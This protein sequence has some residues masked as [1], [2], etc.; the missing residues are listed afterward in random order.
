MS[1]AKISEEQVG[2]NYF[3]LSMHKQT[4]KKSNNFTYRLF[5]MHLLVFI[6]KGIGNYKSC[7]VG[8]GSYNNGDTN[9]NQ[10]N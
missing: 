8:V 9:P 2:K 7:I 6:L 3:E 4:E 5:C 1:N 10:R